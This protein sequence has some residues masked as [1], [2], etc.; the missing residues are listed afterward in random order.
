MSARRNGAKFYVIDPVKNRTGRLADKHFALYPGSDLALALGLAHVI[1]RDGLTDADFISQH[2]NGLADMQQLASDYPPARVAALTGLTAE[3]IELL[4]R[5]YATIKPAAIRVNYGVQRSDRGGSAVRAIA[6][7]PILTGAWRM[8]GGGLQ[9]TTSGAFQ[10][11]TVGLERPDLQN[12]SPLGR[13]ARL[14]NMSQLGHALCELNHPPVK[15]MVVYN[16]NPATIAPNQTK[17]TEGLKRTDLFT[18]VL[19]QMQTDS[20]DFA[21]IVLP[22]TT[23][24]EHTDLYKAYG[25][26]H[27]QL[28]R[29]ALQPEGEA[30]S[31]V[32]IFRLLAKRLGFNEPCFDDSED[33]HVARFA[34]Y[35]IALSGR[36]HA[37]TPGG[38]NAPLN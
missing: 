7:L 10:L 11:N 4:A 2:A 20:A 26:Y 31:N 12:A 1:L 32:E 9:L 8:A 21:D 14:V 38:R 3:E 29:P 30:K 15:A 18:V 28:A 6:A 5:D 37:G 22:V 33:G 24:L 25:H 36:D 35:A 27:L 34:G 13:P 19:E 16:S 23:F 17:V